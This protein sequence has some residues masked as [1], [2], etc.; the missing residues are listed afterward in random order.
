MEGAIVW[1]LALIGLQIFLIVYHYVLLGG[2]R[3][4][5]RIIS[6]DVKKNLELLKFMAKKMD[7]M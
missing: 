6:E 1:I 4:Y 7:T 5:S 3:N 2:I